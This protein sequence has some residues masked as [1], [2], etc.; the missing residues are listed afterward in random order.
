V[1]VL[2]RARRGLGKVKARSW[3]QRDFAAKS[4]REGRR[5]LRESERETEGG[6]LAAVE[7]AGSLRGELL[8]S[9]L[10]LFEPK[11]RCDTTKT[12]QF[13]S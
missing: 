10:E 3:L 9:I 1:E 13:G 7:R 11:S 8:R 5:G 6:V 12:T 4:W 2:G